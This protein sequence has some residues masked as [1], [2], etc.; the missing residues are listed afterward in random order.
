MQRQDPSHPT[1]VSDDSPRGN[2]TLARARNRKANAALELKID[3]ATWEEIA[4]V[5]GYP[6]PRAAK[7]AVELTLEKQLDIQDRVKL[8]EI[9]SRRLEVLLATVWR[10]ATDPDHPEHLLAVS[11]ARELVGDHRK[12][13]GLDSP[14]EIVMHN[15]TEEALRA[16]VASVASQALPPVAEYDII[17]GEVLPEGDDDAVPAD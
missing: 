15:P 11:K 12:L 2:A 9:A 3:G 1:G 17:N 5:L 8:R 4:Q 14:T 6:T 16:W 13:F 7:V 10:K